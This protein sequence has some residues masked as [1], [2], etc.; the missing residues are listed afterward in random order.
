MRDK[1]YRVGVCASAL[2]ILMGSA[3][4]CRRESASAIQ[5]ENE[6]E[7]IKKLNNMLK[8][9]S[10]APSRIETLSQRQ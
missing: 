3:T 4:G 8:C 5:E 1:I 2:L 9:Y 6:T 7:R 10:P